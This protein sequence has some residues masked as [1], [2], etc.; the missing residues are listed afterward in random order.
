MKTVSVDEFQK[1]F[2]SVLET[3]KQGET[4]ELTSPVNG[5]AV[6]ML[7]PPQNGEARKP[8]PLGLYAGKVKAIFHDN[9]EMTDEELLSL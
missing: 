9:W 2:A 8:R 6:A 3:V 4:V 7:V 5:E 1:Q